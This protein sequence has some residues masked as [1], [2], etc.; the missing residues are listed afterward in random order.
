MRGLD[1]KQVVPAQ[2]SN[3]ILLKNGTYYFLEDY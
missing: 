3:G 2:S 1:I